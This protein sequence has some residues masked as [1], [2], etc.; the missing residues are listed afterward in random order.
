M[1]VPCD[2]N[3]NN[4]KPSLVKEKMLTK[5]EYSLTCLRMP[6]SRLKELQK[7]SRSINKS[8]IKIKHKINIISYQKAAYSLVGST[9]S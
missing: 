7:R 2:L 3:G 4:T 6:L 9:F 1:T 8:K 5:A